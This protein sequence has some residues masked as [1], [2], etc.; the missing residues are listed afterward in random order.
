ME[1]N[2]TTESLDLLTVEQLAEMFAVPVRT[3]YEWNQA[4]TGPKRI[5]IGKRTYYRKTDIQAWIDSKAGA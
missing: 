1:E 5:K 2:V 3:V 4:G